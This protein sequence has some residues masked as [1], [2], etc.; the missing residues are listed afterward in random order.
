MKLNEQVEKSKILAEWYKEGYLSLRLKLKEEGQVRKWI[1]TILIFS[2]VL[3]EG[4]LFAEE[5]TFG[6]YSTKPFEGTTINVA[7][8]AEP[9]SDALK[10]LL[11]EFEKLTG[12]KVNM[13]ILPYPTLQE[14]QGVAVT[15]GTGAYD[16]VH[17]D[18][19]W[20][21]Q[22]AGGGLVVPVEEFIE[23]TD[24]KV[25]ALDDFI[26]KVLEERNYTAYPSGSSKTVPTLD[27]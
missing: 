24:P 17:V 2:L 5:Y 1:L 7:L 10:A 22:Y 3:G 25:L 13:D 6:T 26:P 9:R 14:K 8:V 4:L 11:P 19:V 18:C 16:V 27:G 12:I 20:V 15:Q 21:G 23:K